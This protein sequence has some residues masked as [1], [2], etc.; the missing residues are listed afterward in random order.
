METE[1]ERYN[2][3][4]KR[5][6]LSKLEFARSLGVSKERGY[7]LSKG[8]YH[9]SREI[10]DKLSSVYNVNL[11]WFLLGEG[12]LFETEKAAIRL[13]HQ[14][15]AAG[16]GREI[17]DYAEVETLKLPRSLISPY[18]PENLQAVYVAG[19]SMI[20]EHIYNGDAVVFHPGLTEGNGIYVLSLDTALLVK[21]VSFD[22]LPRSISLI[23]ANPAYPPRQIAG[24]ELENLR[25]AGRVVTCVHKF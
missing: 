21:R 5:S 20:G 13:L 2:F 7:S 22:D 8:I 11:N 17:E 16:R 3:L 6:G 10:L 14:E 4:Q 23:S 15:A 1:E 9:A 19:D 18:R 24:S 12:S 25:I